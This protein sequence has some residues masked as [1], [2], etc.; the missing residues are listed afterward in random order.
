MKTIVFEMGLLGFFVSAVIFG[1]QGVGLFDLI[2]RAFIVFIGIELAGTAVLAMIMSPPREPVIEVQENLIPQIRR[3][4][5]IRPSRL[6]RNSEFYT[7][8]Y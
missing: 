4:G 2:A 7:E 6:K 1:A 3:N 8:Y 5:T